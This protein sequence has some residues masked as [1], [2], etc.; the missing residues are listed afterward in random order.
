[1]CLEVITE[2]SFDVFKLCCCLRLIHRNCVLQWKGSNFKP[3]P[4]NRALKDEYKVDTRKCAAGCGFLD[5]V[6]ALS[7]TRVSKLFLPAAADPGPFEVIY[8]PNGIDV[9]N[10]IT[11]VCQLIVP[12]LCTVP[13]AATLCL[14]PTK[15]QA[16]TRPPRG[17]PARDCTRP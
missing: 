12:V 7:R 4:S 6:P 15:R 5:Q 10:P 1:V 9:E 14:G 3:S 16:R 11:E 13:T 8:Y 2:T 17:D